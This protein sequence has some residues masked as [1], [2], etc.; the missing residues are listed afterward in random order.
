MKRRVFSAIGLLCLI[1]SVSYAKSGNN[2]ET[3]TVGS[4]EAISVC[5]GIE[6]YISEGSSSSI[7]VETNYEEYLPKINTEVK[8]GKL[9]ISFNMKNQVN[10]PRDMWVKVYVSAKN[11]SEISASS[12]AEVYSKEALKANDIKISSSSGAEVKLELNAANLKGS[13]SSGAGLKLTGTAASASVSASS[14]GNIN[15]KEMIVRVA[16]ASASSGSDITVYATDEIKAKAS[17]GA[18]VK[19]KGNPK[20][21]NK[22]KSLGGEVQQVN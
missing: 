11:L 15:M 20:T 16:E 10:R 22:K 19:F 3:R 8:K 7:T 21:V 13:A 1:C 9:K 12:G 4:F 6:L 2:A 18:N 17:T 5:C 14:G